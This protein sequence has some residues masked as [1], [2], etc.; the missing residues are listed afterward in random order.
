MKLKANL[1]YLSKSKHKMTFFFFFLWYPSLGETPNLGISRGSY[2]LRV[3][4]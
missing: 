4:E 2:S 1:I 3:E